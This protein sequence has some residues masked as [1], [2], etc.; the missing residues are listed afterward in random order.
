MISEPQL[1]Q[2]A[3]HVTRVLIDSYGLAAE[4]TFKHRI[5]VRSSLCTLDTSGIYPAMGITRAAL[6]LA[7]LA[8]LAALAGA[9]D[10]PS[11]AKPSSFYTTNFGQPIFTD[12]Y[13]LTVGE[14]G[15]ASCVSTPAGR[16]RMIVV[17]HMHALL[18]HVDLH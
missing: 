6:C 9:Q 10:G 3:Q 8:C 17:M 15:A 2:H 7:S 5:I 16:P 14:R 13:S 1:E 11:L 4:H 18:A 12:S